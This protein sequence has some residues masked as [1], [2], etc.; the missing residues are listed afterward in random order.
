[1]PTRIRRWPRPH[2]PPRRRWSGGAGPAC[3]SWETASAQPLETPFRHG[4]GD[5]VEATAEGRGL[6]DGNARIG[7][8]HAGRILI[9]T[10]PGYTVSRGPW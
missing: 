9:A 6:L 5:V 3:T 10:R 7:F 4:G 1:M 2:R 8:D